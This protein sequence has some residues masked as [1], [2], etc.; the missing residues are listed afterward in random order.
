MVK[1]ENSQNIE[2]IIKK[3]VRAEIQNIFEGSIN[4]EEPNDL[5]PSIIPRNKSARLR[6]NNVN[7]NAERL[8]TCYEPSEV[9]CDCGKDI[10]KFTKQQKEMHS[11]SK[12]HLEN[13]SY[14]NK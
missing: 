2:E 1:K 10:T 6:E 13:I 12:F 5:N 14:I 9:I 11:K 8:R 3:A 4:K 7:E